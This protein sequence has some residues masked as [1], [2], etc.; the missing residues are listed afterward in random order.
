MKLQ[1]TKV[2]SC[3]LKARK[4]FVMHQPVQAMKFY[5]RTTRSWKRYCCLPSPRRS[6]LHL[7]PLQPGLYKN[8]TK[9]KIGTGQQLV[10]KQD[11]LSNLHNFIEIAYSSSGAVWN[12]LSAWACRRRVRIGFLNDFDKLSMTAKW[13]LRL[14]SFTIYF[15]IET[16]VFWVH[17]SNGFLY[18]C[19]QW[20]INWNLQKARL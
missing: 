6:Q 10:S 2:F 17:L 12:M 18:L 9:S 4:F 5:R 11:V 13:N 8:K 15:Q 20:R 16:L 1:Q 14:N 19:S 3:L 7:S